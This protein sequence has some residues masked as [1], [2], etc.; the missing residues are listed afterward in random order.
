MNECQKCGKVGGKVV[1]FEIGFMLT[2][3][4]ICPHCLDATDDMDFRRGE[5]CR[6]AADHMDGL[7]RWMGGELPAE[8]AALRD[9]LHACV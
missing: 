2:S 8:W 7:S 5:A 1:S 3:R 4:W 9:E 6:K